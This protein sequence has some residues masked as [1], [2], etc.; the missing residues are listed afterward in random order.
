MEK[1]KKAAIKKKDGSVYTGKQH[2]DIINWDLGGICEKDTIQGFITNKNRFVNR[3]EA[4]IIAFNA[5]QINHLEEDQILMSE[6]IWLYGNYSYNKEQG[7]F[8]T[9]LK[10]D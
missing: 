10:K 7:Y 4:A 8:E 6:E 9:F 2:S 3:K 1:I 5:K